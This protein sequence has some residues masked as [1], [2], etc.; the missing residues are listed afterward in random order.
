MSY[1]QDTLVVLSVQRKTKL[2]A[3][4]LAFRNSYALVTLTK[5]GSEGGTKSFGFGGVLAGFLC[6]LDTR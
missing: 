4:V 2:Q 1:N 3:T 5:I 6:Q